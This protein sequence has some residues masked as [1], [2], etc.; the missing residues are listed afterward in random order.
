MV[1][2][3]Q[4]AMSTRKYTFSNA[5]LKAVLGVQPRALAE[6]VADTTKSMIE[7]GWVKPKSKQ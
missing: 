3:F 6:V 7:G 5:E 2:P 1:S 4:E